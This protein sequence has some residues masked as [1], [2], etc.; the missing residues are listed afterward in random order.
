MKIS[1]VEDEIAVAEHLRLIVSKMGFEIGIVAHSAA[2][3]LASEA[4]KDSNVVLVDINMEK[5]QSGFEVAKVL[6]Q[7]QI[8]F[9]FI[10][11]QADETT[12]EEA[13]L[14]NPVGYIVKPFIPNQ[15]KVTLKTFSKGVYG[16]KCTINIGK[17]SYQIDPSEVL[18]IRSENVYCE[19]I[20]KTFKEVLRIKLQD[21]IDALDYTPIRRVHRSYAV[22]AVHIDSE[23]GKIIWIGKTQ[24]PKSST[25]T[26]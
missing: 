24:I 11:A 5:K 7:N 26:K 9:I 23:E 2:T 16:N 22:N 3:F 20:G 18:Y 1:I 12:L 17:R 8:P 4:Y 14:L 21:L 15:I 10:S 19:I 13:A 25:Y 6:Q